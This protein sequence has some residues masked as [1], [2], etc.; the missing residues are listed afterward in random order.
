MN[1][2]VAAERVHIGFFGR[3]NV[4][5][6]SLMN[7]VTAQEMSVVSEKRGTT[8]DPV[9][10]SMELL[11]IG[12]VVLF[13]TPGLDDDTDL[14][15]LRMRTARQT[16]NRTDLAVLV[17]DCTAGMTKADAE[18][19]SL[20]RSKEIPCVIACNKADAGPKPDTPEG[21]P[22]ICVS[23][24]TGQGIHELKELMAKTI[25]PED[26]SRRVIGD[27]LSSGDVVILV[28][29]IDATKRERSYEKESRHRDDD[30]K[31]FRRNKDSF[32]RKR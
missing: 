30:S 10:K 5:K 7:A 25:P 29:P 8:T 6:S 9:R 2:T 13:D 28:T 32:R 11:P 19:L 1:E 21:V 22:T 27:L 16:L 26:N 18:I 4:G 14:G 24:K 20:I 12:P 31:S 15:E 23:A 3:S 17:L